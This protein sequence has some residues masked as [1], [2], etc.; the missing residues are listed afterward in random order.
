MTITLLTEIAESIREHNEKENPFSQDRFSAKQI[1][2][3]SDCIG[4]D[5]KRNAFVNYTMGWSSRANF[6]NEME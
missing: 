6:I 1:K 5:K 3:I 2:V 4:N